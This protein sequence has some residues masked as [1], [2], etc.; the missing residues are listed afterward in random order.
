MKVLR[1]RVEGFRSLAAL[2]LELETHTVLFGE[3][4]AGV[5]LLLGV[6][7]RALS[8]DDE[9]AAAAFTHDDL[10]C[11][12]QGARQDLRVSLLLAPSRAGEWL[13][14]LHAPMRAELL[15]ERP[16]DESLRWELT[17]RSRG[18]RGLEARESLVS[19]SGRSSA[20]APLRAWRRTALPVLDLSRGLFAPGMSAGASVERDARGGADPTAKLREGF[21]RWS[22]SEATLDD[23]RWE[24]VYPDIE[25]LW[26]EVQRHLVPLSKTS[27]WLA[28]DFDLDVPRSTAGA[29]AM[30]IDS[31]RGTRL[32]LFLLAGALAQQRRRPL[33]PHSSPLILFGD[34]EAQLHPTTRFALL[35]LLLHLRAQILFSTHSSQ[36]LVHLPL[37]ALRRV[38]R[39]G[40]AVQVFSVQPR[41]IPRD[42][43]RKIRYHLVTRHPEALLARAWLLVEG[44]TEAWLLPEVAR[45]SGYFLP[46]EGVVVIEYAQCGL[47][48]LLRLAESLRIEWH[49]LSDGDPAGASYAA[50]ARRFTRKVSAE[51]R[52]S[53]LP[54]RDIETSFW[55]HGFSKVLLRLAG[56]IERRARESEP[57]FAHR[58]IRR[59][60]DRQAKPQVA[61][62]LIEALGAARAPSVPPPLA[63]CIERTV[64]LARTRPLLLAAAAPARRRDGSAPREPR[65]PREADANAGAKPTPQRTPRR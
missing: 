16:G 6:L 13:E 19:A 60:L 36:V 11:D 46:I 5:S 14:D 62:K 26:S 17:V 2:E 7:A 32:A 42:A 41:A 57:A 1:V 22:A 39:A 49:V 38:V 12:E 34:V 8:V 24:E 43:L 15:G 21:A 40:A 29:R 63:S 10:A 56:S 37:V 64:E 31:S 33:H 45:A 54:E 4:D 53:E 30:P 59:A 48:P 3:N 20:A 58:A 18:A 44:E 35:G 65:P 55:R 47:A 25:R 50:I 51:L 61:L 23:E 52:V 27:G 28:S 9:R